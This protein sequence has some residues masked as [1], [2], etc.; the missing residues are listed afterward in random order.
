MKSNDLPDLGKNDV[1]SLVLLTLFV[2]GDD[3]RYSSLSELSYILDQDNFIKFIKYFAG[4]TIA[5][6]NVKQISQS[7]RV[8]LLYQYYVVDR[9]SWQKSLSKAGF[10]PEDNMSARRLLHSFK[11]AIEDYRIGDFFDKN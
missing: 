1:Y 6:P 7:L 8:I 11:Q 5:I 10:E 2:M 9:E 4:Q 3:P